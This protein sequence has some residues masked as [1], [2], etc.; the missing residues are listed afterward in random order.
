MMKPQEQKQTDTIHSM[1]MN[2][3]AEDV[4]GRQAGGL[5]G[6]RVV[7]EPVVSD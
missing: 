5:W 3:W 1:G 4:R 6:R 2:V 7:L